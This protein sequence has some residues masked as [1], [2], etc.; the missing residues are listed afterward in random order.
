MRHE[1]FLIRVSRLLCF[2]IGKGWEPRFGAYAG[3]R[4]NSEGRRWGKWFVRNLSFKI[5]RWRLNAEE[6]NPTK[7]IKT[8]KSETWTILQSKQLSFE[9]IPSGKGLPGWSKT[10]IF[11]L[12]KASLEQVTMLLHQC[13]TMPHSWTLK[14]L[15]RTNSLEM[16]NFIMHIRNQLD[17]WNE[18]LNYLIS[19]HTLLEKEI[20]LK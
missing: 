6:E 15:W 11:P 16:R 12:P 17:G 10:T 3:S 9:V 19:R 7:I 18:D 20:H 13:T 8:K 4:F 5:E 1:S 14:E 2:F